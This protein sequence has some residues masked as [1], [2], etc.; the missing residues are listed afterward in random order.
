MII[1]MI[2][3]AREHHYLYPREISQTRYTAR[4]TETN[5]EYCIFPCPRNVDNRKQWSK[6]QLHFSRRSY[7]IIT[8]T[9][10]KTKSAAGD[11][12]INIIQWMKNAT[13]KKLKS[14]NTD[15]GGEYHSHK[16]LQ[17]LKGRGVQLVENVPYHSGTNPGAGRANLTISA[18]ARTAH[19]H[20][21]IMK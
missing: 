4:K 18:M 6:I 12:V 7:W 21:K 5:N 13:G 14:L 2:N 1:I 10:I 9:T 19:R 16:F 11:A 15:H 3:K 8:N 17:Q 20:S